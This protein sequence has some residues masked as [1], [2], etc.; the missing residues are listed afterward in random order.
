MAK[1]KNRLRAQITVGHDSTG[2]PIYKWASGYTKKELAANKAEIT[3]R[4]I[5]GTAEVERDMLFVQFVVNW[6]ALYKKPNL[7]A[8]SQSSYAAIINTQL[9]P[10]FGDRQLRAITSDDLQR[11]INKNATSKSQV[12]KIIMIIRQIFIA[13]QA[14]GIIDRD[15]AR[16]LIKPN[17]PEGERR[18]LTPA[19]TKASII[20]MKTNEHGLLLALCYYTGLRI[21]EVIGLQWQDVDFSGNTIFVRRDIDY[22]KKRPDNYGAN[23]ALYKIDT[24]KTERSVRKVP[25]PDELR[26]MLDPIRGIGAA[27]ILQ[28]ENSGIFLSERTLRR[29]WNSLMLDMFLADNSIE[30]RQMPVEKAKTTV[31]NK[32]RIEKKPEDPKLI[33]ILT[34]H[35]FRHNYA[36]IL[37]DNGVDVKTAQKWLGH[38]KIET[39]LGIY[40]HLSLLREKIDAEKIRTSFTVPKS[41]AASE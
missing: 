39:T 27:Y 35:Y 36:S 37:Y 4:H 40:A 6:Y 29:R 5:T 12:D 18:E 9:M 16:I 20:V 32:K 31:R 2:A 11:C 7:A 15:P 22:K 8:S 14:K 28:G 38:S 41:S 24:V 34:P 25:L 26:A 17:A 19:E 33:S 21:G 30:S 3:Q 10:E 1:K 23:D 13:A